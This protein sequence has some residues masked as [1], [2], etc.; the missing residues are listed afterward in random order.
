MFSVPGLTST[1]QEPEYSRS[2]REQAEGS[3]HAAHGPKKESV[4]PWLAG[5]QIL[6]EAGGVAQPSV[7]EKGALQRGGRPRL[8]NKLP[9]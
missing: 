3:H 7:F 8:E 1:A 4:S 2:T 5:E 9:K 6:L